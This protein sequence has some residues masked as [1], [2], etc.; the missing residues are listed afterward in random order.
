MYAALAFALYVGGSAAYVLGVVVGLPPPIATLITPATIVH[1]SGQLTFI[2]LIFF[3]LFKVSR[4]VVTGLAFFSNFLICKFY[5]GLRR[6]RGL[7]DPAVAR[8]ARR[9][10][11]AALE[12]RLQ[13]RVIFGFRIV[14]ALAFCAFTFFRIEAS[15]FTTHPSRAM[16]YVTIFVGGVM[17]ILGSMS[18]YR[19]AVSRSHGEFLNSSEGRKLAVVTALFL[20][21]IFGMARTFT[22]LQ[23]PTV[24]YSF[25]REVCQLAPMMP[26]YGG[27]LYFDRE[28]SN[29]VVMS[30]DKI[31][32]YIPHLTSQKTPACI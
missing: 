27:N 12:G 19:V 32:L 8:L 18:A 31:A 4:L 2:A 29:F 21:M 24:Y 15:S 26:V 16:L 13:G 10:D 1:L 11:K 22:M 17:A 3:A 7:R 14:I 6:P 30:S 9:M 28:S 20:C 25:G 5:F 23:G